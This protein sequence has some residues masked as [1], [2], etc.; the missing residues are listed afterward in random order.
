MMIVT[1]KS[2]VIWQSVGCA[3]LLFLNIRIIRL[4]LYYSFH[5]VWLTFWS[6][7]CSV[8]R[9][10]RNH[11]FMSWRHRLYARTPDSWPHRHNRSPPLSGRMNVHLVEKEGTE[12]EAKWSRYYRLYSTLKND[13]IPEVGAVGGLPSC[14]A[15]AFPPFDL[16]SLYPRVSIQILFL[17][18]ILLSRLDSLLI[19]ILVFTLA[20]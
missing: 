8:I 4:L 17:S 9:S 20:W 6:L 13:C 2:S 10:L 5:A 15:V 14:I 16:F 19:P 12:L 1:E 11:P 3:T 7:K 18:H